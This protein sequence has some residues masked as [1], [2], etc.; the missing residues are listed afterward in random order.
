VVCWEEAIGVQQVA[1]HVLVLVLRVHYEILRSARCSTEFCVTI[2]R[3]IFMEGSFF[4]CILYQ[5]R[6][7]STTH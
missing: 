1:F 3:F 7:R 2:S 4:L 5:A 6:V